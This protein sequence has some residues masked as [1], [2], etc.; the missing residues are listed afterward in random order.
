MSWKD[1]YNISDE[2]S[3]NKVNR[4]DVNAIK[5]GHWVTVKVCSNINLSM[6]CTDSSYPSEMG[7]SGKS[8]GFYPL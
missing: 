6:R 2:E 1:N 3:K 4:G 5:I 7:M 8:R